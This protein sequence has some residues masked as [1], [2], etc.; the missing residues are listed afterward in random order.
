MTPLPDAWGSPGYHLLMTAYALAEQRHAA[1]ERSGELSLLNDAVT[2]FTLIL[3]AAHN[4]D[5]RSTAANGL[6]TALWSRFERFGDP[7]DLDRAVALFRAALACYPDEETA[8]T[9]IFYANLAGVLTL[10]WRMTRNDD[11]VAEAIAAARAALARTP[12]GDP[13]RYSRLNGLAQTLVAYTQRHEDSTA[14]TEAIELMREAEAGAE[15]ELRAYIRSNLAEALRRQYHWSRAVDRTMILDEAI[16][17]A[18]DALSVVRTNLILR[19]RFESNLAYLLLDRYHAGRRRTD[20]AEA[21]ALAE[22]AVRN[23]PPGHPNRVERLAALHSVRRAEVFAEW[24]WL[25]VDPR[26]LGVGDRFVP[27]RREASGP[28]ARLRNRRAPGKF[29]QR[30]LRTSRELVGAVPAGHFLHAQAMLTHASALIARSALRGDHRAD[31]AAVDIFRRVAQDPTTPAQYRVTAA[32]HWAFSRMRN[33]TGELDFASAMPLF[34]QAVALLPRA[35]A[36][37]LP[38]RDRERLLAEFSGLARDA[39]ACAMALKRPA[40]ALRLLEHGRGILLAQA[41]QART[42][43]TELHRAHPELARR[44]AAV[45]TALDQPDDIEHAGFSSPAF[46]TGVDRHAVATEFDRLVDEIRGLPGFDRFLLTPTTAEL[47][48]ELPTNGVVVVLSVSP[49]RCDALLLCENTIEPIA[50]PSLTQAELLQRADEFRSATGLAEHSGVDG[51][52]RERARRVIGETLEWLWH[53]V[54]GP[55]MESQVVARA[56]ETTE[57]PRLWWVPTGALTTL[58][59]H[60]AGLPG[61]PYVLD[62]AISSY[63]PTVRS[64]ATTETTDSRP[65]SPLIIGVAASDGFAELPGVRPEIAAL[66]RRFPAGRVLTDGEA[67]K[68]A[69]LQALPN[70]PWAHFACHAL[71][72][73]DMAHP[74]RLVLHDHGQDPL[75]ISDIARL[76]LTDAE[77]AYLSACETGVSQEELHDES[78]HIVGACRMAGF[79]HVVGTLWAVADATAAAVAADFYDALGADSANAAR[80]VHHAVRKQRAAQPDRP[81][82]WAPYVHVGP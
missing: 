26:R 25:D 2:G 63:A 32:Q 3:E 13:R 73:A 68:Q 54:A 35:V 14:L 66:Q 72:A 77:L 64:L 24:G 10:R 19:Q 58:P 42:D 69:V 6:G 76:R 36:R 81:T 5:I 67:T 56:S 1:Y 65:G 51:A 7:A 82:L 59:L 70:H 46:P 40:L 47:T 33:D 38:H 23:T 8:E 60:A 43:L 57:L 12:A 49:L 4:V 45:Q 30:L 11:D 55:I 61:G 28:L 53:T 78:L 79:R 80:A 9:P 37:Q 74:G 50:L 52:T 31:A 21:A 71:S 41:I 16:G 22:R 17:Y 39:A 29:E 75:E 62:R 20:L 34:E 48:R 18:R 44:F 15:G 27:A